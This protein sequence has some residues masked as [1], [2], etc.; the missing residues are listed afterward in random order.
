MNLRKKMNEE[1]T[2]IRVGLGITVNLGNYETARVD[3]SV[4]DFKRS[5]E[6]MDTSVDRI[7]RFV[8]NK[9]EEK[10]AEIAK[11]IKRH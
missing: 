6:T 1:A 7:Y 8:E 10:V 11:D 2:K 3:I 9:V 4:E 5:G